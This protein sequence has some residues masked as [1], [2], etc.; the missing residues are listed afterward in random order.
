MLNCYDV[1]LFMS[2]KLQYQSEFQAGT[3]LEPG[4]EPII[5]KAFFNQFF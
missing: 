2:G 3:D 1:G 4:L 5:L